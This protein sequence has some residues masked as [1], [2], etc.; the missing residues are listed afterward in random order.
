MDERNLNT[1]PWTDEELA[2]MRAQSV[3]Y[4]TEITRDDRAREFTCDDCEAR[5]VCEWAFD[6]YNTHGDCLMEK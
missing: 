1:D 3:A 4:I 2:K 6:A 5:S